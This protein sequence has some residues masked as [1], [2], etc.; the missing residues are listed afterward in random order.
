MPGRPAA[1]RRP[2]LRSV[3]VLALVVALLGTAVAVWL[4]TLVVDDQQDR[5]LTER[6]DEVALVF[7]SAVAAI[8]AQLSA[9]GGILRATN[10]SRPA[11]ERAATADLDAVPNPRTKQTFAW[12]RRLPDGTYEVL[13][14][15]GPQLSE[16]DVVTDPATRRA[17][18]RAM[19]AK[20][21]VATP[22]HGADRRLGFALGPP[23]APAG[24]VLLRE[25]ALGPVQPPRA[26][27]TAP[28]SELEVALY[29]S[30]TVRPGQVLVSTTTD[31]PM[32]G[33]FRSK[34]LAAGASTWV[35][36]VKARGPLVGRLAD[37]APMAILVLGVLGSLL[38]VAVIESAARRRDAAL[39][40]YAGEHQ[41]AETLQ[42]S[43]LPQLPELPGLDLAARYL[44]GGSGQMVGGDWFDVFPV[45]GDRVGIAVGD[46]I[47]HDLEAASAMAQIRATL[48][49]YA[50][51][52]DPPVTVITRLDHLVDT[53]AL[54]Q[55]VTVMYG[56]LE[57][58]A[59]DGSRLL[60][61]TNAG[62][63]P[64]LLRHPSGRVEPLAGGESVV[65]G[66][67]IAPAHGQAER[68]VRPG[69]TLVLFTDGL[70]ERP[71]GSLDDTMQQL[72]DSVAAAGGD[73]DA[74]CEHVL[75]ELSVPLL[76]DDVALL[77]V[78]LT[79]V[80]P[81][82][83]VRPTVPAVRSAVADDLVEG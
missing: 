9:Q 61:W 38:I 79:G 71:G 75:G 41:L 33:D 55:L 15:A 23:A 56:V 5:L 18:D 12:L 28:F 4:A 58:P 35:L 25:S 65:I 32:A 74:L 13:A 52:G 81:S 37:A 40:L 45:R 24:T 2:Q 6:T 14:A 43:L 22:V 83:I 67:P 29:A 76:R 30:P 68:V 46:V 16:G 60:R 34:T 69:S 39:A 19:S 36:V 27:S 8:P 42:R 49:A 80:E 44:A 66:A 62:H 48:R 21:M 77:A 26:A 51:D 20:G 59:A 72:C 54:T 70:V 47:G 82:P 10:G 17:L 53:F 50:V 78:R 63:L 31:L 57:P 11:Y 3:S 1:R 7:T 64:P 73:A